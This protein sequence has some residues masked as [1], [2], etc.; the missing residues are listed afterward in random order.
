MKKK[1]N[2]ILS[3]FSIINEMCLHRERVIRLV[4]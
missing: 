1:E 2:F 3:I 4:I